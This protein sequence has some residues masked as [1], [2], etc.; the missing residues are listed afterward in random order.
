MKLELICVCDLSDD[1]F[2]NL[3]GNPGWDGN[4]DVE[5]LFC[6]NPQREEERKEQ[7]TRN[8]C[9]D[10]IEKEDC[11]SLEMEISAGKLSSDSASRLLWKTLELERLDCLEVM[12]RCGYDVNAVTNEDGNTLLHIAVAKYNNE[13]LIER[14]LALG[15]D[16]YAKNRHG[17]TPWEV[18]IGPAL[19][20]ALT[21]SV[22]RVRFLTCLLKI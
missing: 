4:G 10:Y 6:K 16:R 22:V 19:P 13:K 3:G 18:A 5:R 21:S 12:V 8:K 2:S 7:Q 1:C 20:K 17:Q 15:A 11:K 14:L 9:I